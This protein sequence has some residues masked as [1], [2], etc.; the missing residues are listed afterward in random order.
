MA[1]KPAT[2]RGKPLKTRQQKPDD[3]TQYERFREFAREVQADE[4]PEAFE[5]AFKEI[6]RPR[7]G[8]AP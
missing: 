8:S 6:V 3:P 1:R 2:K 5:R 7:R 4:N